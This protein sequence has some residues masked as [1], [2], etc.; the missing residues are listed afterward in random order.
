ME[1]VIEELQAKANEAREIQE[2]TQKTDQLCPMMK[3]RMRT[4]ISIS[5]TRYKLSREKKS[6]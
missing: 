4:E 5:S 2:K 1:R 6:I 3:S